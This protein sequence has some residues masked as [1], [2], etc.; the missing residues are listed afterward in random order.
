MDFHN[1]KL[2]IVCELP[3]NEE[4]TRNTM[5]SSNYREASQEYDAKMRNLSIDDKKRYARRI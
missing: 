4:V 2:A 5:S 3:V 1:S